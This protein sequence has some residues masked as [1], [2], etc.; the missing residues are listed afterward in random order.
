[1]LLRNLQYYDLQHTTLNWFKSYILDRTQHVEYGGVTSARKLKETG[2]PQGSV[3]GLLLFGIYMDHIQ[4]VSDRLNFILYADDTT[5][6]STLCTFTWEVNHDVNHISYLINLVPSK[7]SNWFDV[8]TVSLNVV[9]KN[10]WF[11]IATIK[12]YQLTI[13]LVNPQTRYMY[14]PFVSHAY[15]WCPYCCNTSYSWIITR[16][17]SKPYEKSAHPQYPNFCFP[18]L[19]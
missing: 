7:I 15:F 19:R 14:A 6:T 12:W 1:M 5:L 17:S 13:S 9:K 18:S 11:F 2:V 8:D 3:L 16:V 4:T 10:S